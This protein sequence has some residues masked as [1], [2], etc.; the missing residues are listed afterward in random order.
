ML[1][2]IKNKKNRTANKISIDTITSMRYMNNDVSNCACC[3]PIDCIHHVLVSKWTVAH[4]S[5]IFQEAIKSG[6]V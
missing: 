4:L 3:G 2:Y 6:R 5:F 1:W